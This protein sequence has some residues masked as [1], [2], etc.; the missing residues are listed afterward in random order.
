MGVEMGSYDKS[1]VGIER[2]RIDL[3][4]KHFSPPSISSL[5]ISSSN[6]PDFS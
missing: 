3:A 4:S 2:E 6:I 1:E 5:N